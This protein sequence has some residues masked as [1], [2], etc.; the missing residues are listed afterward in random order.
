LHRP[1]KYETWSYLQRYPDTEFIDK[2]G[3]AQT[4]TLPFIT[5]QAFR[6]A[7]SNA[8][9]WKKANPEKELRWAAFKNT[10]VLHLSQQ[11]AFSANSIE[12]AGGEDIV[13]YSTTKKG[14]SWRM[15]VS[16]GTDDV[17]YGVYPGGQSGNPGSKH[18]TEFIDSWAKGEYF[19]LLYLKPGETSTEI[20]HA[21]IITK[22]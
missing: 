5:L 18:Y 11:A 21:A 17:Y 8:L 4:E 15:V 6:R 9:A 16:P 12:C 22:K 7:V 2:Q 3:T 14:A 19:R 13:N 10:T 1:G 20:T